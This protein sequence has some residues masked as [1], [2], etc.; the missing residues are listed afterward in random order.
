VSK[1]AVVFEALRSV[2]LGPSQSYENLSVL[3][4]LTR[5][6]WEADYATL[7]EA[8]AGGWVSI[9]EL[10]DGGSVPELSVRNSGRMPVLLLDGEELVGA[11]QNRV[12][13]LTILVPAESTLT[14]PVSCVE[15]GRWRHMSRGFQSAPRAQFAEGRA[16]K[17]RDVT[18]SLRQTGT[19][20]SDQGEVWSRIAEKSA[21]LGAES[22][23]GAMAA[24]FEHAQA[25]IECFVEALPSDARQAGGIFFINGRIV[26]LELFD[27]PATWGKLA[28]KLL[29][30]YAVDAIDRRRAPRSSVADE[31]Q[32]FLECVAE[33]E[34]TVFQATGLGSDV[35]LSSPELSGAALAMGDRAVHIS[36][37]AE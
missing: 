33:S 31:A 19:R 37:F 14:I 29:R 10:G 11:K 30:S 27:A 13:N 32:R 15:Q 16:A 36:A 7:D 17:M 18:A 26:G 35:R 24:M 5:E 9:T 20:H 8:L 21:R 3:P 28:P 23:T 6:P 2:D 34:A 12:L 25:P 4:L 22:E 1:S